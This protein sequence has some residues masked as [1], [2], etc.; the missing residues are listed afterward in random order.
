VKRLLALLTLA[1]VAAVPTVSDAAVKKAK[2]KPTKRVVTWSYTGFHAVTTPAVNTAFESPCTVNAEACYD[3]Q[4]LSYEK[5]VAVDAGGIAVQYFFDDTYDSVQTLCGRGT[6]PVAKGTLVTLIAAIDPSCPGAP[7]TS[8]TVK[9]TVTG[10][11]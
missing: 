7:P 2:P 5:S 4:T 10:L 1:A 3:L 6:I 11:K 9:L 8:G